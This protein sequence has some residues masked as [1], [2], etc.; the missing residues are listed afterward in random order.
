[1][2]MF[3]TS[4][5][6]SLEAYNKRKFL[7]TAMCFSALA[8]L[9]LANPAFAVDDPWK[10]SALGDAAAAKIS[11]AGTLF[12]RGVRMTF[13]VILV[14]AIVRLISSKKAVDM[15]W[16]AIAGVLIGFSTQISDALYT[17]GHS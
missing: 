3:K 14:I 2:N 7:F 11:A 9:T 6:T 16:V 5:P 15:I 8:V 10:V 1:M 13:Y 4:S 17:F 12:D